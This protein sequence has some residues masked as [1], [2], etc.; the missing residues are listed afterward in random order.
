MNL[1]SNTLIA[2]L[3]WGSIGTGLAVY[4]WKRQEFVFLFGGIALGAFSY[5]I[6]S[7]LVMSLV[8]AAAIVLM[9]WLKRRF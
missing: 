4:G 3:I 5:F 9:F 6:G 1:D 8:S 7:A 2:S